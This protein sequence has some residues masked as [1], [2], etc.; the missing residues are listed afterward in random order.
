ML[1][2]CCVAAGSKTT[3][4]DRVLRDC[5]VSITSD[6]VMDRNELEKERG[7]TIMSKVT[8]VTHGEHRINGT[9]WGVGGNGG[10]VVVADCAHTA[11]ALSA[12]LGGVAGALTAGRRIPPGVCASL[13]A[14]ADVSL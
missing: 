12:P 9:C 1:C 6:R 5:N 14:L 11:N 7:I 10:G 8:S 2:V 13:C 4:V 3:L